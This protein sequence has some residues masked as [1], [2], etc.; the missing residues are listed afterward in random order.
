M[1]RDIENGKSEKNQFEKE[2]LTGLNMLNYREY[3]DLITRV[4]KIDREIGILTKKNFEL[5]EKITFFL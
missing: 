3:Y 1:L 5:E 4:P 2:L